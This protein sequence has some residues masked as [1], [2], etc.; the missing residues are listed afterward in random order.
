MTDDQGVITTIDTQRKTVTLKDKDG[1]ETWPLASAEAFEAASRAWLRVGWD[2]KHLY[3]FTWLGRPMLQLPED[4]VRL[5]EL[6][7]QVRP[8]VILET[9]VA[10]GG[11][12]VFNATLCRALGKG[13]TIGVER[14]LY[15]ENREALGNHILSDLIT[16]IEGDSIDPD[17]VQRVKSLIEPHETVLILLDSNH[18]REHVLNELR[19]YSPLVTVGSYIIACDGIISEFVGA[20]R[21]SPD[22]RE[23]NPMMAAED[24]VGENENFKQVDPKFLFNESLIRKAPTYWKNGVLQRIR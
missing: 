24:F 11:S 10:H 16:V 22:W 19:A 9:G 15:P 20:E 4:M 13:R 3:S 12:L 6:V 14:G 21:S 2:V 18:T 7:W 23:N 5:Q 8:D 1:E 17:V